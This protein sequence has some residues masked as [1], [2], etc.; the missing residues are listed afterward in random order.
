MGTDFD[1]RVSEGS[2][3]PFSGWDFS[4]IAPWWR[5]GSPPWDYAHLLREKMRL[6]TSMVD[7]GTGGGEFLASLAPLPGKAFATEGYPPN[8]AVAARRLAPLGVRVLP[9]GPDLRIDLPDRSLDLVADRHESFSAP[10][11]VRVLRPGG[12]FVT[13]QVGSRDHIELEEWF[14]TPPRPATDRVSDATEFANRN[15]SAA[16]LAEEVSTAGLDVRD[17]KEATY[18]DDFLDIGALVYYLRAAP[19]EVPG[20][21]VDRD[22]KILRAIDQ[23]IQRTEFFRLTSHRLLVTAQRPA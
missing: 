6:A 17:A 8:V 18:P 11:V 3:L 4:P 12:W 9:I 22:R 19:W 16:E 1:R 20:F 15:S 21:S 23:E 5:A 7:L 2:A 14:R 13:Q 10:E